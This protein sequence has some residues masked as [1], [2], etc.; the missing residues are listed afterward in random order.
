MKLSVWMEMTG[1]TPETL[2]EE[3][4]GFGLPATAD[5]IRKVNANTKRFGLDTTYQ[6]QR[7]SKGKVTFD[8]LYV[9]LGDLRGASNE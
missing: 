9:P 3:L 7:L 6:L 2:S 4:Q 1:R 8:D 5:L